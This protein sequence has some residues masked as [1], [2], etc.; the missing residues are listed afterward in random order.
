MS[1]KGAPAWAFTWAFAIV[2]VL[3]ILNFVLGCYNAALINPEIG[4]PETLT[5]LSN[6]ALRNHGR[7]ERVSRTE[8]LS[9][10][11]SGGRQ[12]HSGYDRVH[13]CTAECIIRS[14]V[15]FCLNLFRPCVLKVW[16]VFFSLSPL[17]PGMKRRSRS[18]AVCFLFKM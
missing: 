12:R 13:Y 1:K 8:G 7:N 17:P 2:L 10:Q 15:L 9:C 14:T 18:R 6:Q 16:P 4:L 5:D 3:C 11:I